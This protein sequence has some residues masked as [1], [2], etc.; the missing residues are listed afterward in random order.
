MKML[1]LWIAAVGF[2]GILCLTAGAQEAGTPL[3]TPNS[4]SVIVGEHQ[5]YVPGEALHFQLRFDPAPD[6]YGKGEIGVS[7]QK[8]DGPSSGDLFGGG[9]GQQSVAGTS[10]QLK[11]G[12]G[13]YSLSLFI[14]ESLAAGK[15]K[16]MQVF[17][18]RST[19]KTVPVS[20]DVSFDIPELHPMMVHIQAPTSVQAGQ[21]YSFTVTLDEYPRDVSKYCQ[22]TF[23]PSLKQASPPGRSIDLNAAEIRPNQLSYKFSYSFEPDFPSGPW[24]V[25]LVDRAYNVDSHSEGCRYPRL[26]GDVRHSFDIMPATGL[27]TPTSVGVTV[28][29]SQVELLLEKADL[30]KAKAQHLRQD[31]SSGDIAPDQDSMRKSLQT[32]LQEATTELDATERNYKE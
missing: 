2:S 15:W 16:L 1:K 3:V 4:A 28:N 23:T 19:R 26:Q 27:A 20:D 6:G 9:E 11:D 17:V 8:V 22:L 32:S 21:Q 7:F 29:P 12:V 24:Q 14:S 25:E 5:T 30:L 13:I 18:G 10:T 31:L